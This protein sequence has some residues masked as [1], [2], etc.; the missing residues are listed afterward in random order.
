MP[1]ESAMKSKSIFLMLLMILAPLASANVTTFSDGSSSVDVEIRDGGDL[2]NLVDGNINLPDGETVTSATMKVSTT[3]VE[4]GAQVRID[5]ETMP[6][7]WNPAYNNQLTNFSDQSMFVIE[8]GTE[9]TPVSLAAEG[10]LT[11]FE[12]V[13]GGFMDATQPGD[14][15]ASGIGW[16]HGTLSPTDTPA[17]CKSGM[18]C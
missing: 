15:P 8:D 7:V 4:H 11:D 14:M 16:E 13:T 18:E 1:N 17:G 5:T 9:A 3:M 6:R 10:F 12:G 2:Q